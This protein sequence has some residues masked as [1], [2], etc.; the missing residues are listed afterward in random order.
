MILTSNAIGAPDSTPRVGSRQALAGV[1]IVSPDAVNDSGCADSLRLFVELASCS[2]GDVHC[3][4]PSW[5]TPFAQRLA[6][7]FIRSIPIWSLAAGEPHCQRIPNYRHQA[8]VKEDVMICRIWH[9]WTT[10]QNADGYEALLRS[11]IFP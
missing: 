2:R 10:P 1:L 5:V 3:A 11:E 7:L 6:W 9:G 4:S 8:R